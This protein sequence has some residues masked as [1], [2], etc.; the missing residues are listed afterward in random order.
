MYSQ[1]S[2]CIDDFTAEELVPAASLDARPS[3]CISVSSVSR[4]LPVA[5][6][7]GVGVFLD[8]SFSP[9]QPHYV[10]NMFAV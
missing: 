7:T 1:V 9:P 6:V 8:P 4:R 2:N 10:V 5:F 3:C